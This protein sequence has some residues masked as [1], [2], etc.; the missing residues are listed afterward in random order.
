MLPAGVPL[1]FHPRMVVH[2]GLQSGDPF[3]QLLFFVDKPVA[4]KIQHALDRARVSLARLPVPDVVDV[5]R[6]QII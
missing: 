6:L 5:G 4:Q 2:L 3:G 1:C